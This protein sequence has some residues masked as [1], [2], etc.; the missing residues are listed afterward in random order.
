MLDRVVIWPPNYVKQFEWRQKQL[1]QLTDEKL[2]YGAI[3]YYK[4]HPIEFIEHWGITFDPRNVG[5]AQPTFMPFI[6]FKRQKELVQFVE[7][8]RKDEEAGLVEKSRDMGATWLCCN[9]S[10]WLWRFHSGAAV[11][12]GS[13]KSD[14]VDRRGVID[15]I[16]E[17]IRTV[18]NWLPRPLWPLGFDPD[19]HMSH[20]RILNPENGSSIA[21]EGGDDL[22]R[23]G[24]T[25]VYFKDESAHY[26]HPEAIEAA[27]A[28]NTRCQ[29]DI[30]SVHGIGNVFHRRREAGVEW[31]PGAKLPKGKTRIFVMDWRDHPAKTQGWY[32]LMRQQYIDN[33]LAHI[34]A[35][36]V[37]RNYGA[38]VVGTILPLEWIQA[39]VDAHAKLKIIPSGLWMAALDVADEGGDTNALSKREG[40]VLRA[41]DE[42]G[43]RDTGV[44]TRRAVEALK[45]LGEVDLQYD[46]IGV[47]AG[48]KSEANRLDDDKLL[49]KGVRFVKWEAGAAVLWPDDHIIPGDKQSPL[50]K[51]FY[52]NLKAQGWWML[53]RRFEITYR[54][55]TE[56]GFTYDTEDIISLDSKMPLLQKLIKELSQPTAGPSTRMKL[57]V[58]KAPEGSKSPNLADSVMMNYWPIPVRRPLMVSEAVL[59]RMAGLGG[60]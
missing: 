23:G 39:A 41:L 45:G 29:I 2:L 21:G 56:A 7:S 36:E 19:R 58:N 59:A 38:S 34:F 24:R 16:F 18:V 40:V 35:Q 10:V 53:R 15:S 37:D 26:E 5:T 28:S 31:S 49:P 57:I 14:L 13:R 32:E 43:E 60:R 52:H 48:V 8:C 55:L 20:M 9:Y 12:W 33:G 25:T 1:L 46:A 30:S 42:W 44:T 54:A 11:G 50:N 27:L 3:E 6:L 47:G 22:G 51:D 17:K 4:T